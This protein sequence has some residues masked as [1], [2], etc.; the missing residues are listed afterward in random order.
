MIH[1]RVSH[2][3]TIKSFCGLSVMINATTF[4]NVTQ[5][6]APF[7]IY[8]SG[9]WFH[10]LSA[11]PGLSIHSPKDI[12]DGFFLDLCK[13]LVRWFYWFSHFNQYEIGFLWNA[14]QLIQIQQIKGQFQIYA[15][16]SIFDWSL[17]HTQ[18]H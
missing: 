3:Q 4:L 6:F 5:D 1:L 18:M 14:T 9:L 17:K 12:T 10:I 7:L 2:H 15:M 16:Y 13:R 8:Y 11:I